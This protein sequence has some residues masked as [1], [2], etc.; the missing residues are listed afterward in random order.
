[1]S[2]RLC[3]RIQRHLTDDL[4]CPRWRAKR[5]PGD[6]NTTGHCYIAAEAAYHLYGKARGFTPYVISGPDWT[7]W[8]LRHPDG[9]ILD[10][11]AE[12][13]GTETIPYDRG[14]GSGFL[15]RDPSRRCRELMSRVALVAAIN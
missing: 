6:H 9:R 3:R 10:P 4:L 7:H 1:M 15:T 8:Y 11:T 12:Q 14:R 13:W 5:K 2:V